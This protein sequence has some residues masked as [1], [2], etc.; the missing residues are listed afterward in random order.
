MR[1]LLILFPQG[2]SLTWRE[3][4]FKLGNVAKLSFY[5]EQAIVLGD[6]LASA[7]R[8]RFDLSTPHG[9]RE[10]GDERVL[11]FSRAMRNYELPI[12]FTA[13]LDRVDGLGYCA[14][15]IEL[16]QNRICCM[17]G[18]SALDEL[19]IRDIDV[20]SDD[21]NPLAKLCGQGMEAI[22][23]ILAEPI[24]DRND[25]ISV[26]PLRVEPINWPPVLLPPPDFE[27]A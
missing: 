23:I 24:L 21:L 3:R 2:A 20:I 13:H 1:K 14:D 19:C 27:S 16:N 18:N 25:G 9:H 15:L 6:P 4:T 22:P 7:K 10:V 5:F 8:T 26:G 11:R 17:F 12:C